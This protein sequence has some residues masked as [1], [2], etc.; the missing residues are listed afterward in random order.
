M[1]HGVATRTPTEDIDYVLQSCCRGADLDGAGVSL[2]TTA[3]SREPFHATDEIAR[4]IELLQVTLGEGPCVDV[5]TS[6]TPVLVADLS[7][8]QDDVTHRWPVFR[9]E[10]LRVGVRAIFAFP[11]Q[12]GTVQLGAVDLYRKAPGGLS[13]R[14]LDAALSSVDRVA[15]SLLDRPTGY[16]DHDPGAVADVLVH[17]AAGMVMVQTNST[18]EEALV[19]LRSTAFS[20]G[21]A[22]SELAADVVRGRRRFSEESS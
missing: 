19:R 15:T 9:G 5:A 11:M 14:Q 7:D 12:V 16:S 3:G 1:E 4:Q 6:R 18:I 2:S 17:Q 20:E 21:H 10:A 13:D 22:L 8:S